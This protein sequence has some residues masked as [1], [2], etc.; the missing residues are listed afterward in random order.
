VYYYDLL[1]VDINMPSINGYE[2]VEKIT[3]LDLNIKVC[4]MSSGEANSEALQEIYHPA[5]SFGCFIRKPA[6]NDYLIKRVA[7]ELYY[8][9]RSSLLDVFGSLN[10]TKIEKL[11]KDTKPNYQTN[12]QI[13]NTKSYCR[14]LCLSTSCRTSKR[15]CFMSCS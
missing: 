4:F 1:L 12:K 10:L 7:Q 15:Y 2:L 8:L 9:L 6:T 14:L 13:V 11:V 5:R 3:R